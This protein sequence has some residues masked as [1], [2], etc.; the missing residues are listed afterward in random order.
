MDIS[1]KVKLAQ[2]ERVTPNGMDGSI[3]AHGR[4]RMKSVARLQRRPCANSRTTAPARIRPAAE[5]QKEMLPGV[6]PSAARAQG[7][8]RD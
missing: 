7:V 5:G 3:A 8:S 2:D 4:R 6:A 1:E